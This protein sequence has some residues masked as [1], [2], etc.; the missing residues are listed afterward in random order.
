MLRPLR[1]ARKVWARRPSIC[2]SAAALISATVIAM[3]VLAEGV[4]APVG[5]YLWFPGQGGPKSD[6]DCRDLVARVK[7]TKGKAEMSLWGTIPE[8]DP[9]AGSFYLL[10][11]ESR[12]EPTYGAEGDYD[13]G[14]VQLGETRDG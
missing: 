6:Q 11:S 1:N 13:F 5:A 10:L 2:C 12:M 14:N 4:S 9:A 8:N 7:L 3:P